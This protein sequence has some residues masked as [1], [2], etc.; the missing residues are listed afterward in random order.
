APCLTPFGRRLGG[1]KTTRRMDPCTMVNLQLEGLGKLLISENLRDIL[2][3]LEYTA[4][5][6]RVDPDRIGCVGLSLGGRMTT[7]AAAVEPRIKVAVIAGALNLLQERAMLGGAGCQV[8][9]GLL[10]YGDIPEIAGLI[11]PRRVLW[12]V[13]ADDRLMPAE[14]VAKALA[15]LEPIYAAYGAR[16]QVGVDRFAGGHEWHESGAKPVLDAELNPD[17]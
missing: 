6:E 17:Q 1:V 10:A 14:W 13:G 16:D 15:R 5:H 2:W 4:R 12:Q 3:T 8:I 11:A 9:P 7:L